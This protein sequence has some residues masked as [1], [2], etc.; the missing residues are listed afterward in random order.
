MYGLD[1]ETAELV[2]VRNIPRDYTTHA[3]D[4]NVCLEVQNRQRTIPVA[5]TS[6]TISSGPEEN[7][8]EQ[9]NVYASITTTDQAEDEA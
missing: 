8:M 7:E 3:N 4:E 6:R 5:G 1:N 9:L 2:V